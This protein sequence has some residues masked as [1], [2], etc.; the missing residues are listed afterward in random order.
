MREIQQDQDS[1]QGDTVI[2]L[3]VEDPPVFTLHGLTF[4]TLAAYLSLR[5]LIRLG[6]TCRTFKESLNQP[7]LWEILTQA[8]QG[9][10]D[11]HGSEPRAS[12]EPRAT[13]M[14]AAIT[15]HRVSTSS[16]DVAIAG[17]SAPNDPVKETWWN[18]VDGGDFGRHAQLNNI[19]WGEWFAWRRMPAAGSWDVVIKMKWT[20]RDFDRV[21]KP[22]T[23]SARLYPHDLNDLGAFDNGQRDKFGQVKDFLNDGFPNAPL[24][25]E[26]IVS[27]EDRA[28]FRRTQGQWTLLNLGAVTLLSS[29]LVS[30]RYWGCCPHWFGG[31]SIDWVAFMP[32]GLIRPGVSIFEDMPKP[33]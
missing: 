33:V 18:L 5:D 29:G 32:V 15:H 3:D 24:L 27:A 23:Y 21:E 28:A 1:N 22:T 2:S 13:Y 17:L 10:G 7:S 6:A 9:S 19:C 31:W 8:L 30:L 25:L 16:A 11:G 14:H 4:T 20:S 26:Y 12:A